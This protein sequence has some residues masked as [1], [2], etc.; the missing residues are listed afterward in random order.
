MSSDE[1]STQQSRGPEFIRKLLTVGVGTIFLTEES[2]R[3]LV[4]E[5]KLPKELLRGMLDSA[6]KTKRDF[7]Q[8]FS[9]EIVDRVMARMEPRELV[10]EILSRNDI[11]LNVRI[12]FTP[13]EGKGRGKTS[14]RV[15][16]PESGEDD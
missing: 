3:S 8:N 11:E 16:T 9:R 14:M 12:S 7:L 4:S 1:E 6:N 15:E 5:V 13:K 2:L 10:D